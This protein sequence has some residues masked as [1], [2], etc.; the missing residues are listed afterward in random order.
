MEASG[1]EK[2]TPQ[3]PDNVNARTLQEFNLAIR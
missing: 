1:T 3:L 2:R